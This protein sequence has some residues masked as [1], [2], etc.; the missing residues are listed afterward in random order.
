MA[1]FIGRQRDL[2][3]LDEIAAA[4]GAQ[5]VLVYGRRR[6]GKTTLLLHWAQQTGYPYFYWMAQRDTVTG[7]RHEFAQSLWQWSHPDRGGQ[8]PWR[9]DSWQLL[10]EQMGQRLNEP[11]I[12]IFD[13]FSYAVD[14]DSSLP[15]HLQAVWDH[16]LKD[17]PVILILAGSLVGTMV[18]LKAYHAPLYG[19]F[20]AQL[21]VE[22][23]PFP[24]LA[25]FLPRYSVAQR[26]AVSAI[27]G[28]IP[29]Y[30]ERWK[31][32]QSLRRN[33]ERLFIKRTGMFRDEPFVLIADV[34][35]RDSEVYESILR[36]IAAGERTPKDIGLAIDRPSSHLGFYLQQL[37][38]LGLIDRRLS[39]TIPPK[40]RPTSRESRYYL[41]DPYLCFYFR[42][43]APNL[44]LVEQE[45]T[46]LVWQRIEEGIR[47]FVGETAFEELSREWTLAQARAGRLPFPPEEVGS[48]WSADA[49]VDV[50][51]INWKEQA[52]LLGECKW[53]QDGIDLKTVRELLD[54]TPLVVPG[55]GWQVYYAFFSRYGFTE[56]AQAA[57]KEVDALL[58]GL[59]EIDVG[60]REAN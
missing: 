41:V 9:T 56:P 45:L 37:Q 60:L 16:Q 12:L 14:S 13:E 55:A 19:R 28:G 10:F 32:T 31:D 22:P 11:T 15:S 54:K 44:G 39:V 34:I 2:A 5:F 48:H 17:R 35:R 36:A 46:S 8:H 21:Q 50:V 18:N 20:T 26:V 52:I 38:K 49:Q 53:G 58:V 47:G 4:G 51:A 57:A 43:I 24:D 42:F 30:L 23:L 3:D 59:D 29:A 6:V 33:V 1:E 7:L 27:V 25:G 40:Q